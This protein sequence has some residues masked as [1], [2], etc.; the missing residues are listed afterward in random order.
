[1]S[2]TSV[3][4]EGDLRCPECNKLLATEGGIKCPRCKKIH[5]ELENFRKELRPDRFIVTVLWKPDGSSASTVSISK[6]IWLNSGSQSRKKRYGN[7]LWYPVFFIYNHLDPSQAY[8][9]EAGGRVNQEPILNFKEA[10]EIAKQQEAK[11]RASG[12]WVEVGEI[13]PPEIKPPEDGIW[14]FADLEKYSE[15]SQVGAHELFITLTHYSTGASIAA[16]VVIK[17]ISQLS[18][19]QEEYQALE[20]IAFDGANRQK[21]EKD[22]REWLILFSWLSEKRTEQ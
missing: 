2:R 5:S 21:F 7:Y 9:A 1:M 12:L 17:I 18:L 10:W 14:S 16:E 19:S 20:R 6:E 3:F 13:R 15:T 8:S 4:V 22:R 11:V